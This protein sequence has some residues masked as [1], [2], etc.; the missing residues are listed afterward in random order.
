MH[1]C[2]YNIYILCKPYSFLSEWRPYIIWFNHPNYTFAA[3]LL[4]L[5]FLCSNA[6]FSCGGIDGKLGGLTPMNSYARLVCIRGIETTVIGLR[7]NPATAHCCVI[8]KKIQCDFAT[9]CF[10]IW[11]CCFNP[12]N[13]TSNNCYRHEIICTGNTVQST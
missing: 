6:A 7:G 11:L 3:R 8:L 13:T 10:F 2:P 9:D 4:E 5:V 1:K 12:P